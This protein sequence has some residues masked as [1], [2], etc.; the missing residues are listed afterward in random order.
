MSYPTA[1]TVEEHTQGDTVWVAVRARGAEWS[2][3]TPDEAIELAWE[4]IKRYAK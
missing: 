3:V 2:W 4:W 1:V